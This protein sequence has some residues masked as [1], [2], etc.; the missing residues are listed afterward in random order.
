MR[1]FASRRL[2]LRVITAIIIDIILQMRKLRGALPKREQKASDF[3]LDDLQRVARMKQWGIAAEAGVSVATN[4]LYGANSI[5][6]TKPDSQL[7]QA[8]QITIGVDLPESRDI[9]KPS[10]SRLALT[11]IIDVLAMGVAETKP[12]ITK[13]KIFGVSAP[14]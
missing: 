8:T 13:K 12:E 5:S 10:A 6:L 1:L 11:A 7:A 3:V 9:C 2:Q 14:H 4:H